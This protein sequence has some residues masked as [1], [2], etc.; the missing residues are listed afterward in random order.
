[1]RELMHRIFERYQ[2]V[3]LAGPKEYLP[4]L[5]LTAPNFKTLFRHHVGLLTRF[6]A[7]RERNR[8]FEVLRFGTPMVSRLFKHCFGKKQRPARLSR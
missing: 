3:E 4:A 2:A 6:A 1:M 8:I 7:L 5:T